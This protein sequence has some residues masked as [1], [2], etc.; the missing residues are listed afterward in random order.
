MGDRIRKKEREE[1]LEMSSEAMRMGGIRD[2][3]ICYKSH[4]DKLHPTAQQL[5][6]SPFLNAS[7]WGAIDMSSKYCT[8]KRT[9][10]SLFTFVTAI[11]PPRL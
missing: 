10:S 8:Y 6:P 7:N 3:Y 4:F 11:S 1:W 2:K 9:Y 5:S